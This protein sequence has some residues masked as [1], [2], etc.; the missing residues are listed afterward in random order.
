MA[1]Q[2]AIIWIH[3]LGDRGASWRSLE[4]DAEIP[5]VKTK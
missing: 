2:L 1:A 3:G 5:G 4:D